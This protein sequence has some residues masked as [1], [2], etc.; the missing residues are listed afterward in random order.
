MEKGVVYV[1]RVGALVC[2]CRTDG[3]QSTTQRQTCIDLTLS[4][5]LTAVVTMLMSVSLREC[6]AIVTVIT[7]C[8]CL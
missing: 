6:K 4:K 7:K 2:D 8:K 3:A 5:N 1:L